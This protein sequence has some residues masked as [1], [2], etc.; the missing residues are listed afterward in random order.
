[1]TY[2]L[3]RHWHR[4]SLV[5]QHIDLAGLGVPVIWPD[6]TATEFGKGWRALPVL[7][8][9]LIVCLA[10]LVAAAFWLIGPGER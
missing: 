3:P 10:S 2:R 7:Q 5:K 6:I 9:S 4:L 1:L 8:R